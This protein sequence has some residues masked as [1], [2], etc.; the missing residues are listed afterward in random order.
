VVG[1]YQ[2][3]ATNVTTQNA[4][5]FNSNLTVVGALTVDKA[6]ISSVS[7]ISAAN[8]VYDGTTNATLDTSSAVFNG[9]VSGDSLSVSSASGAFVD[10]T[11]GT[12]KIVNI[13]G[14]TLGGTDVANYVLL[15]PTATTTAN[16]TAVT[17]IPPTTD[18]AT[19]TD[20]GYLVSTT[21]T[22]LGL[23]GNSSLTD[24]L[25]LSPQNEIHKKGTSSLVA[26]NRGGIALPAYIPLYSDEADKTKESN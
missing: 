14:V 2:L 7:G 5:N 23:V 10:P 17:I 21:A 6:N 4:V 12:A 1:A 9:K 3:G 8:K 13:S 26:I 24:V 18:T 25:Q 22:K 15:S 16:I 20:T 19:T 11:V